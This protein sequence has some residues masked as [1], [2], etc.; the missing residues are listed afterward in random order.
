MRPLS[1]LLMLVLTP[2]VVWAQDDNCHPHFKGSDKTDF[3]K[4]VEAFNSRRYQSCITLMRKVSNH[5]RTAADPYFYLGAASV[6][7]GERPATIRSYFTKLFK[8][9]PDYPNA[10]AYYY[11][12]VVLYSYKQYDE[13]VVQLNRYFDMANQ[14]PNPTYD[15]VYEEASTYL[16]WSEFLAEAQQNQAPFFPVVLR[17]ASS[18]S[19]EYM[20]YISPD[21]SEIYYLRSVRATHKRSFYDQTLDDHVLRM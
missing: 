19:D 2:L 10:L 11:M 9:C 18:S 1:L 3:E 15:A 21:G 20:P 16:Y 5:N 12:G 6:R 8:Y 13:A 7:A 4:G 17:G 14:Q